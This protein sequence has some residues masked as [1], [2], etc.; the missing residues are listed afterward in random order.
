VLR[1]IAVPLSMAIRG[2]TTS[3]DRAISARW[4]LQTLCEAGS[5]ALAFDLERL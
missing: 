5:L 3:L 4:A 2:P 1:R